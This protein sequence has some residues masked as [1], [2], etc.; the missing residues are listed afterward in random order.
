[1]HSNLPGV[2]VASVNHYRD[3]AQGESARVLPDDPAG[4]A[5][6]SR[7]QSVQPLLIGHCVH[8]LLAIDA[9]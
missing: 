9:P 5:P 7:A 2:S 1:V 8:F 3:L 4:G 6:S